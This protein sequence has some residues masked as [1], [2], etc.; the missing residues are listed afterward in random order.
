[1]LR[2]I[3]TQV[4]VCDPFLS[5]GRRKELSID[6]SPLETVLAECDLISLHCSLGNSTRHIIGEKELRMMKAD[7]VLVN[8]ARGPLID[9]RALARACR[10]QWIA[11]AA[12]DVF[13]KEPPKEDSELVG[14]DNVILTPHLS[15]YSEDASWEIRKKIME[16]VKRFVEGKPPRFPLNSVPSN[17]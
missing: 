2:G 6:D 14:L 15:W 12:I 13:E 10:E 4:L 3:G 5:Q 17:E 16:D 9:A 11:G 1:M 8:T 7:A